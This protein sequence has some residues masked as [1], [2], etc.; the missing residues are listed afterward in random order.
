[1][2][3]FMQESF[4]WEEALS[5]HEREAVYHFRYKQ[6]FETHKDLPGT[7]AAKGRVWL[8][9]DE[10]SRHFLVRSLDGAIVGAATATLATEPSLLEEWQTILE[11]KRLQKILAETVIIS[12][13]IVAEPERYSTLFGKICLRLASTFLDQGCHYAVHYCAPA[14]ISL[15]ERLGYRLYGCG[16]NLHSGVYRLPMLLV[17]DD[18]PYFQRV[19]SPFRTLGRDP[20]KNRPWIEKV[21]QLC[22]ELAHL[23]LCLHSKAEITKIVASCLNS[24]EIPQTLVQSLRR[25]AFFSLKKGDILAPAQVDEGSFLILSGAL[26]EGTQSYPRGSV[27]HTGKE[28]IVAQRESILISVEKPE[29]FG[30]SEETPLAGKEGK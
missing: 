7:D 17:A 24:A 28:T 20:E 30:V 18:T 4:L 5:A 8:P 25:G 29:L 19:R 9:H 16:H 10:K 27:V 15:Y 1:M 3:A 23:P 13:A 14:R 22:P 2:G 12:R 6:Y 11:L 21:F 26:C